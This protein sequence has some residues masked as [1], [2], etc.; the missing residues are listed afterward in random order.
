[1]RSLNFP[2]RDSSH[3]YICINHCEIEARRVIYKHKILYC[4][5]NGALHDVWYK[6]DKLTAWERDIID[7]TYKNIQTCNS[8]Q[9]I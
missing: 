2:L 8:A 1:M 5:E 7:I 3:A 9:R 4:E 6:Y